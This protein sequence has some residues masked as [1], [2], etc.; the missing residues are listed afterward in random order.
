MHPG[1]GIDRDVPEVKNMARTAKY[2]TLDEANFQSE[3]L[4]SDKPVMVDFWAEWCPPCRM[5]APVI[6]ELAAEREGKAKVAKLNVD[7]V[8][9]VAGAFGIRSIPTIL[10]FKNG[11]V[12]DSVVGAVPKGV[13]A[14]KLDALLSVN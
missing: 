8:P 3:V 11:E 12:V 1:N 2:V 14:E 10:F 7:E 6:E 13:L 4:L 5:V 9:G